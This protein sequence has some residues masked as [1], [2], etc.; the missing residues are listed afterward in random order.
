VTVCVYRTLKGGKEIAIYLHRDYKN[1]DMVESSEDSTDIVRYRPE[2][3]LAEITAELDF[4]HAMLDISSVVEHEQGKGYGKLLYLKLFKWLRDK[5]YKRL[6]GF[7][8]NKKAIP[9]YMRRDLGHG[10]DIYLRSP[11]PIE[12]AEKLGIE[13]VLAKYPYTPIQ[14]DPYMHK[15]VAPEE[16]SLLKV[17][18]LIPCYVDTKL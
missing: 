17:Q 14:G 5:K 2:K 15:V 12:N 10:T 8:I 1:P 9:I 16:L 7:I 3:A 11:R 18:E 13:T 6:F 4:P